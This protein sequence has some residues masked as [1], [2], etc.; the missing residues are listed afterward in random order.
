MR[1]ARN[2]H[3][4]R[5]ARRPARP[6]PTRRRRP[7][8]RRMPAR[9]R[10]MCWRSAS[11]GCCCAARAPEK[12]LCL[13]YTKAA[14]ANMAN[15]VFETLAQWTPL[16]D[17]ALDDEIAQDR[18]RA[19]RM[20]A[21]RTHAR[22]LFAQA[23]DTPGGLK[24]QTIHAFCTRL[25]HQFPFEADVAARFEVLEDR[26]QLRADRS[27]AHGRAARSRRQARQRSRPRA[28]RRD[29][30]RGGPDVCRGDRRGDRA[31]TTSWRRGSR[32]PAASAAAIT[33]LSRALGV[34]PDETS[35]DDRSRVLLRLADRASEYP[36]VIAALEQGLKGD[37]EH[38]AR[39]ESLRLLE[40]SERDQGLSVDLLHG[41]A[42]AAQEH[43]QQGHPRQEP[44]AVPAPA[45]RT[46]AR[47]RADRAPPRGRDARAHRRARHHRA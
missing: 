42:R 16:D 32:T 2:E 19:G 1:K 40:G 11:S 33:E 28:R 22:R 8:S 5:R 27:A 38:A 46:G 17:D 43:R 41:R 7:G 20:R 13:T 12:I 3:P 36:A 6:R 25:L 44:V 24:V 37:K 10:R 34:E 15:R 23:L 29:H 39:F 4:R 45:G 14:A 47:V 31:S 26:T 30:G 18:R 9:A 21:Q 35:E